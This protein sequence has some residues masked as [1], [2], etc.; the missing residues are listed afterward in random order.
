MAEKKFSPMRYTASSEEAAVQGA[1]AVVGVSRDDIDYDVLETGAKGVT[2]RIKPRAAEAPVAEAAPVEAAPVEVAPVE[3]A[4][5]VAELAPVEDAAPEEESPIVEDVPELLAQDDENGEVEA[6]EEVIA[7]T[8]AFSGETA[9]TDAVQDFIDHGN[10]AEAAPQETAPQGAAPQVAAA[11]EA[12]DPALVAQAQSKAQEFLDRMGLEASAIVSEGAEAGTASL[13]VDGADVGI[14]IGKHG[15]TLQSFQYL[16]NLTLNHQ[17]EGDGIRVVVDAGNYRARRQSSLEQIARGA[18]SKARRDAR[19]VRLDPMP[20]HERRLVHMFLQTE[21]DIYTQS[22]GR[23][24]LRRIVVSPSSA[25]AA[26]PR[27]P[28]PREGSG[29]DRGYEPRTGQGGMGGFARRGPNNGGNR[30]FGRGR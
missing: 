11:P 7:E 3:V 28:A 10:E 5:P 6:P 2:V 23:E 1:L 15:A 16:L 21:A 27:N 12:L 25:P 24:P 20:A 26:T 22:E 19:P 30:G 14:L 8:P 18:A 13:I 17:I 29:P 4:A 9:T